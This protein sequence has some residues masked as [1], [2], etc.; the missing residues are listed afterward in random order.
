MYKP[1]REW[2]Y[3]EPDKWG[4]TIY[5]TLTERE[6]LRA[7]M[8]WWVKQMIKVGK[9]S[10]ISLETCIEDFVVVHWAMPSNYPG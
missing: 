9:E 3:V 8:P 4:Q 6:I 10:E 7:Y 5:V 1:D 2:T